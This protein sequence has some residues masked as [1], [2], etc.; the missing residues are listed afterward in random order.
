MRARREFEEHG[1]E[2]AAREMKAI[3]NN[4][5]SACRPALFV[6]LFV[7][8]DAGLAGTMVEQRLEFI[9][10]IFCIKLLVLLLL[11]MYY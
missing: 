11:R 2:I 4:C 8:L 7:C 6:C 9:M 3:D 5:G 10:A 1:G